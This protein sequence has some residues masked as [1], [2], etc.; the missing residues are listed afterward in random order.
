MTTEMAL[1][2]RGGARP[3]DHLFVTGPLGASAAGLR[4]LR[5]ARG[6][7]PCP[8]RR[9]GPPPAGGPDPAE[10]VVARSAGATACIDLSDGLVADV[11]HLAEA[12]DVGLD[13]VVGAVLV[14]SGATRDE[15][16]GGGEDYELL[17]ATP[18]PDGLLAA[19]ERQGLRPPL[20]VG[21]CVDAVGGSAARRRA[22]LPAGGWRH[23]LLRRALRGGSPAG[24]SPRR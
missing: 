10:G 14:A 16:L 6:R 12:S 17:M 8:K 5:R 4:L 18:D 19:F 23:A 2:T 3:G 21:A 7:R 22:S 9:L 20:A 15:A 13:L 1:L 11:V 24:R